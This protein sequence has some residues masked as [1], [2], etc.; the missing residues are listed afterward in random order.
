MQL[1]SIEDAVGDR[2]RLFM[3]GLCSQA[4]SC[5]LSLAE[6]GP[7]RHAARLPVPYFCCSTAC[8]MFHRVRPPVLRRRLQYEHAL[9]QD[10][11]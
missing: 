8:R 6:G 9:L 7:V 2:A 11:C 4:L 1:R 10:C 3:Q 5:A